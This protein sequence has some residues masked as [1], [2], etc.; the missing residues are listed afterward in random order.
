[1]VGQ[2][3]SRRGEQPPRRQVD[4]ELPRG[5]QA[6]VPPLLDR[7]TDRRTGLQHQERQSPFDQVRGG[8][9]PTGPAPTTTTGPSPALTCCSFT[10]PPDI[11]FNARHYK[12]QMLLMATCALLER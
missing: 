8:R 12:Q 9:E 5:E 7:R 2:R 11:A 10:I 6:H 4:V 3:H 1:T